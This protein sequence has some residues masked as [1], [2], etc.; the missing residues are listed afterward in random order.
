MAETHCFTSSPVSHLDRASVLAETVKRHHPAWTMWLCVSDADPDGF[1]LN[2]KHFDHVTR[3][4]SKGLGLQHI[5]ATGAAR[6]CYIDP[7]VA[8][9]NPLVHVEEALDAHSVVL[10]PHLDSPGLVA[11]NNDEKGNQFAGWWADRL[12]EDRDESVPEDLFDVHVLRDACYNVGSW[13]LADRPLTISESG[14]ILVG[15]DLLR[16]FHFTKV[17]TYGEAE[18]TR[19]ANGH[20]EVFELLRWY[21]ERLAHHAAPAVHTQAD[22][23]E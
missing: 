5:L 19:A 8:V 6:V 9:F 23:L 17:D 18:L 1:E 20:T 10:T 11:V 15:T 2:V 21:R 7:E 12:R 14:D 22:E 4:E 3:A 13:N 16:F